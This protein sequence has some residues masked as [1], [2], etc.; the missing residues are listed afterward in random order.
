MKYK[1][2]ATDKQIISLLQKD[3]KMTT[4][5]IANKVS[6]SKTAVFERIRKLEKEKV[7]KHYT[8][9]VDPFKTNQGFL[10]FC[11]V[12]L[13]KHT[14]QYLID[15]EKNITKIP[16]I[17]ECYHVSGTYD[18]LLKIRLKDISEYREFMV[19]TLTQIPH[20]ANT[21]SAFSIGEIK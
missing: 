10:A 19:N 7:I 16:E 12:Q 20:I 3:A 8:A 21:Q 18:Y 5:A 2:D 17:L 4:Q 15:F 6:L 9:V 14:Q 13:E 11:M 1:L